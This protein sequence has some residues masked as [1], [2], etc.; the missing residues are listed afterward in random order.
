MHPQQLEVGVVLINRYARVDD[1]VK[2]SPLSA[3]GLGMA[4]VAV[5][6]LVERTI[7]TFVGGHGAVFIIGP[8]FQCQQMDHIPLGGGLKNIGAALTCY[9]TGFPPSV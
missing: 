8:R 9:S 3:G 7:Q 4:H 6:S 1:M 5:Q 2:L